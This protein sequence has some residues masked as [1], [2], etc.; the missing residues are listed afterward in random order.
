[1]SDT[2]HLRLTNSGEIVRPS[3][4]RNP[5]AVAERKR[6]ALHGFAA[7][8][9]TVEIARN[10]GIDESTIRHWEKVDPA[11]LEQKQRVMDERDALLSEELEETAFEM[12]KGNP[13]VTKD[14]K[15]HWPALARSLAVTNPKR[16]GEKK[17][18][19]HSGTVVHTLIPTARRLD[20]LL[21]LDDG[22]LEVAAVEDDEEEDE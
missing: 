2:N 17:E 21:P 14:G 9:K 13:A 16:W 10:L 3:T 19:T 22:V 12:A 20:D 6:M 15:P 4:P 11:Y 18:V 5:E 8:Q 1:M 7:G